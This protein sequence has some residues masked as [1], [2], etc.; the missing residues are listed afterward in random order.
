MP[1]VRGTPMTGRVSVGPDDAGGWAPVPAGRLPGDIAAPIRAAR[2]AGVEKRH[3]AAIL[4]EAF[5]PFGTDGRDP[6]A[7]WTDA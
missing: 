7:G 1:G 2:E 5:P 6:A 4:A 3:L